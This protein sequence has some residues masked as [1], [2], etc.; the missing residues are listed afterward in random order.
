[1]SDSFIHETYLPFTAESLRAHFV[2]AD[3]S[4]EDPDRHTR[5]WTTRIAQATSKDPAFV[6]R[7]ETLWTAGALVPLYRSS[8]PKE[9]WR[10]VLTAGFGEAPP[11]GDGASW[12]ELLA[13][14]DLQLYFEVG[15]SSPSS[16]R[17]WLS[18]NIEA[19]H[20]LVEQREISRTRGS[21][22]E[23]RTHL[24]ALLLAP[25]TG[26]AAHF[27]AKVLSDIDT[28][29]KHDAL[30]NQLARNLDCLW[31]PAG[32]PALPN[33]KPELS[34]LLLLTPEL[35]RRQPTSRLYGTL[36]GLYRRDP[37]AVHEHLPHLSRN[38]C[39]ELGSRLGWV[40]FEE[41]HALEPSACVWLDERFIVPPGS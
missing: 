4:G 36:F 20:P 34:V 30:R 15:L 13:G 19:R 33:R 39:Q 26:F 3:A 32:V 40:T 16:Y 23:G 8:D 9:A 28:K 12:G 38:E 41:I 22:L 31:D 5:A 7:D 24:D 17:T 6:A 27:E 25:S 1:L 21:S 37:E 2:L 11:V 35:F 18:R 10:R 29:T 14:D